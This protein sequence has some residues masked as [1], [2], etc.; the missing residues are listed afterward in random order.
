MSYIIL[1]KTLNEKKDVMNVLVTILRLQKLTKTP[2][3]YQKSS[4][5][6]RQ[7]YMKHKPKSNPLFTYIFEMHPC[8]PF[9]GHGV[10]NKLISDSQK[11]ES[12]TGLKGYESE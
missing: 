9:H 11:R 3:K 10:Q 4:E 6:I 7:F 12:H 5:A 8:Y 2:W 1:W